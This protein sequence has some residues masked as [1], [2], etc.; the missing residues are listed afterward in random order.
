MSYKGK[1]NERRKTILCVFGTRPEAIKMCPLVRALKAY[2]EF[3]TKVCVTAQHREMLDEVLRV[4]N[5]IPDIDLNLMREGNTLVTLTAE[6]IAGISRTIDIV[7]PDIVLVHGDTTT[8]FAAALVAF[9]KRITIGHV[10]AGLRSGNIK[11]PF[12]EEFNRRAISMLATIHFAP[13]EHA[14]QILLSEGISKEK[15]FVTGNTVIDT[16]RF[17]TQKKGLPQFTDIGRRLIVFTAHRREN[18]GEPMRNMFRALRRI[19]EA[20]EDIEV[21]Y[22]IH[23]NPLVRAMAEAELSGIER[24]ICSEPPSVDVFHNILSSCYLILT[25]SGGI[26]EEAT[27]L[28]KPTL[29]MRNIT[30]RQEGTDA[31]VLRLVGCKADEIF[32]A[33]SEL[34]SDPVK[35]ATIAKPSDRFGDGKASERIC[36]ALKKLRVL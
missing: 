19:V 29:V 16:L 12:P 6:I 4:F 8:A 5:I 15:I 24:V 2:V 10:E 13:T 33:A 36:E 22:P 20:F 23:K 35:Y 27:A 28:G 34:L 1:I 7:E 14:K 11:E 18:I 32:N 31:G 9:Y 30:E 17:T 3:D 21:F 25:D 26:Q